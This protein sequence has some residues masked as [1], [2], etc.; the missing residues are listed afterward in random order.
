[1]IKPTRGI[2][3]PLRGATETIRVPE[4]APVA[5]DGNVIHSTVLVA[6]HPQPA[7]AVTDIVAVSPARLTM[8]C[9]ARRSACTPRRPALAG[10]AAHHA[11]QRNDVD[12]AGVVFAEGGDAERRVEHNLLRGAVPRED[13]AA[14]EVAITYSPAG[15]ELRE[16]R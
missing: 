15:S 10:D 2:S 16:P 6:V 14:A 12:L 9:E 5:P 1:M 7:G 4:P 3:Q 13:L 8:T 11:V